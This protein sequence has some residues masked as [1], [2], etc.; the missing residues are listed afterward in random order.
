LKGLEDIVQL[1]STDFDITKDGW[2]F[3][4]RNG[5]SEK[6]PLYGFKGMKQIYLKADP[7]YSGRYTVPCL[8]DK[9]TETIVNNESS[10]IIRMFYSEF[11]DLLPPEERGGFYPEN[12][13]GEIDEMNKWGE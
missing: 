1:I 9:K 13:R 10:E 11:D 6:E 3:T 8:W 5:S 7:N 4:G 2:V 12:L